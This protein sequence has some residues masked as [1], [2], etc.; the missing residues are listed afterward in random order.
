M[1]PAIY[2]KDTMRS[3]LCG[4]ATN[5]HLQVQLD[6]EHATRVLV[7][8]MND[9]TSSYNTDSNTYTAC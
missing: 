3:G 1:S 7:S 9:K 5:I 6:A 2:K 8:W 4:A